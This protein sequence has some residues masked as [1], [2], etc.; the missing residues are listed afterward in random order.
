MQAWMVALF[1]GFLVVGLGRQRPTR[2][3]NRLILLVVIV[4]IG[5]EAA[6]IHAI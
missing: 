1:V 2:H 4:V 5:Y 3:A 6:K